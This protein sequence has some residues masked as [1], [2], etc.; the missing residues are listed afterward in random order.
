[1]THGE[2]GKDEMKIFEDQAKILEKKEK[3]NMMTKLLR[4]L[5]SF[6]ILITP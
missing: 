5:N 1:M 6:P 3:S 2:I 4:A